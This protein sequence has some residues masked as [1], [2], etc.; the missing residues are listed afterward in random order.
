MKSEKRK[1]KNRKQKMDNEK[2]RFPIIHFSFFTFHFSLLKGRGKLLNPIFAFLSRPDFLHIGTHHLLTVIGRYLPTF[3]SRCHVFIAL[4][5]IFTD[6]RPLVTSRFDAV[7]GQCAVRSRVAE[8]VVFIHVYCVC[9]CC[10]FQFCVPSQRLDGG[11]FFVT[12]SRA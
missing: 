12:A 3:D 1:A 5:N 4:T 9:D 8:M 10:I 11:H 2:H 6:P 7:V